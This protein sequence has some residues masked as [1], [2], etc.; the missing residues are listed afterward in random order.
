LIGIDRKVRLAPK[1]AKERGWP[2]GPVGAILVVSSTTTSRRRIAQ[3]EATFG[4][5]LPSTAAECRR[6]VGS[7]TGQPARG[8]LFLE[9]P[10]SRDVNTAK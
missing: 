10:D 8:I 7:P 1:I 6:W 4:A 9:S 2:I 5:S 3:H